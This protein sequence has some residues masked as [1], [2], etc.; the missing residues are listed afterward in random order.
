MSELRTSIRGRVGVGALAVAL[1]GWTSASAA[2]EA[3]ERWVVKSALSG[4]VGQADIRLQDGTIK[5]TLEEAIALALKRNL[6]L[7]LERYSRQ[8]VRLGIQQA[9]GVYDLGLG[10]GASRS[11]NESPLSSNLEG[12]SVQTSDTDSA[13]VGVSQLFPTGGSASFGVSASKFD[14]NA[15]SYGLNP[16]YNAGVQLSVAQPLLRNFGKETTEFGIRVARL[17]SEQSKQQFIEQVISTTQL[18]EN[19]YW[20]LAEAQEQLKV[21]EE[22]KRIATQL[23]EDNKVR[24]RVGTLAPLELVSSEA[25]IATREEEVIS[26]TAA[27]GNAE[28][29]LKALLRLEGDPAWSAKV[30]LETQPE[31]DAP[32]VDLSSSLS[33]ALQQRPEIS[34][35][36]VA[37]Q[38]REL[39]ARYYKA[40]TKPRLDLNVS[41]GYSG[42]GG[43]V[44]LERDANGNPTQVIP[45]GLSDAFD[46]VTGTDFPGWSVG[47]EF[48]YPLQNRSA[49]ARALIAKL[50]AEQGKVGI[51]QIQQRITTE[52][53]LAVR[54]LETAKQELE[55]SR[56]SVRLQNANLDAEK[57][58]FLNGLSTSFQILQV[59]E[60]LTS[61][62]SR[63]VNAVTSY[64]RALVEYYRSIGKL[65]DQTGIKVED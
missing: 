39:E 27:I 24:V 45:G 20:L 30:E 2:E 44:I 31:I 48:G 9:M 33:A 56:V 11:H 46:Q 13:Q 14:T 5:L 51:T 19:A 1:L 23:H 4:D 65:L 41:Y 64:R 49:K 38:S 43:D 26:A 52:V 18:V 36:E 37:Q 25:G 60:Q 10:G 21:A 28:D 47:L 16:S 29:V 6:G 42:V 53:R 61:A 50:A 22:S 59:E 54:G 58:K 35:E 40:Q 3:S 17:S 62:R 55:S 34:A 15:L 7:E 8:Q 32:K 12:V 57:K 63:E